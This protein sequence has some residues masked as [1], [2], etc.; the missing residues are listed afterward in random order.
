MKKKVGRLSVKFGFESC[1]ERPSLI[2]GCQDPSSVA[3]A[4]PAVKSTG[5]GSISSR[6]RQGPAPQARVSGFSTTASRGLWAL[7]RPLQEAARTEAP[8]SNRS[9]ATRQALACDLPNGWMGAQLPSSC[10][11]L[12]SSRDTKHCLSGL[13]PVH[14]TP[15]QRRDQRSRTGHQHSKTTSTAPTQKTVMKPTYKLS[16]SRLP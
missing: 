15:N 11:P 14:T 9:R 8:P 5:S 10:R 3:C 16:D 4:K 12:P 2:L 13:T 7:T 6:S 1:W